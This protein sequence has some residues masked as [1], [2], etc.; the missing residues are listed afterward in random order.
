MNNAL[1]AKKI[2]YKVYAIEFLYL[3]GCL[4]VYFVLHNG[5]VFIKQLKISYCV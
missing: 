1:N 2:R 3:Y 5:T 4:Y